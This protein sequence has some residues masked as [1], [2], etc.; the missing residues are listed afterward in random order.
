MKKR[1]RE[2]TLLKGLMVVLL[3]LACLTGC[4]DKD[5]GLKAYESHFEDTK[6]LYISSENKGMAAELGV[7]SPE[8]A[9][10]LSFSA[11][12][13]AA[14]TINDDTDKVLL[15]YHAFDKVYPASIT[16]VMTALLTMEYADF[17]EEVTLS[18]NI[19][20]DEGNV[21]RSML[22]KGDTVTVEGL[23]NALLVSSDND[24][25]VILAEHIAGSV[26]SFADM[27]NKRALELGATSTH[28]VNANGL[29]NENHYTTAY[30]LY[31]IFR[32]AMKHD[33]FLSTISQKDYT[34]EYANASGYG[35]EEYKISTNAYFN[36]T[37]PIPTGI[38]I[39]GGKTGTTSAAKSCLILYTKNKQEETVIT[40]V[41]GAETKSLL[42]HTM[43][44]LIVME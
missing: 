28:F 25:A 11:N 12:V 15:S 3:C 29:H 38:D 2:R 6:K 4:Q 8:Q 18:H 14:L 36:N 22:K 43:S 20:F 32:E 26:D 37:Y 13:K 44:D 40:V 16:K 9:T 34:L 33:R 19:T 27:M 24:C 41:L 5:T 7:I 30:D 42:Y 17:E 10:D 39:V 1:Y 35:L 31:L 21:V 23:Y